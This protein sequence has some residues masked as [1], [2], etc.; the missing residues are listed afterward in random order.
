MTLRRTAVLVLFSVFSG[1]GG[2]QELV[3]G[4]AI[5]AAR[6]RHREP[7]GRF[8][9]SS[10]ARLL[11]GPKRRPGALVASPR[12]RW[13]DPGHVPRGDRRTGRAHPAR[14]FAFGSS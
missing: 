3:R 4:A 5:G 1:C 14:T 8:F 12:S 11:L 2:A 6:L 9:E 13:P 7:D 10:H